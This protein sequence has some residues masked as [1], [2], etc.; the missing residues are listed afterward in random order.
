IIRTAVDNISQTGRATQGVKV[1][2]L[3]N[4]A[5][6]VT[7]ALVEPEEV[8]KAPEADQESGGN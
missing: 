1:M 7:F 5:R 3:D 4:S 2:R 6:I 8:V